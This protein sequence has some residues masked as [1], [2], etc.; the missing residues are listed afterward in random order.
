MANSDVFDEGNKP[1]VY[2]LLKA[3]TQFQV[4]YSSPFTITAYPVYNLELSGS[5]NT[6]E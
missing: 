2:V 6:D 3:L 4:N 1:T 5:V